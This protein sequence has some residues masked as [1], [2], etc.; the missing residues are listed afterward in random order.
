MTNKLLVVGMLVPILILLVPNVYASESNQKRFSDGVTDGSTS[1]QSDSAFNISC[2][3]VGAHTS[4]GQHSPQYCSGWHNGYTT[5]WFNIHVNNQQQTQTQQQSQ[6]QNQ[7]VH[8]CIA[9]VCKI[10]QGADQ[11]QGSNQASTT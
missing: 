4:D 11:N 7:A 6:K 5:T 8:T 9:L 10:I 1:A 2:D 3:P